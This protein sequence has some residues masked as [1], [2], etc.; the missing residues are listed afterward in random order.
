[1]SVARERRGL[2]TVLLAGLEALLQR[3]AVDVMLLYPADNGRAPHFWQSTGY[4]AREES[5]LPKDNLRST[6]DGGWLMPEYDPAT[7]GELPRW[8]KRLD[9]SVDEVSPP[10][11]AQK[12][13][14]VVQIHRQVPASQSRISGEALHDAACRLQAY[15]KSQQEQAL[16]QNNRPSEEQAFRRASEEQAKRAGSQK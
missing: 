9:T 2:G 1:M 7:L 4:T 6:Q 10:L 15:R 11:G 14:G 16:R 12:R 8:E 3:E 13:A 5:F